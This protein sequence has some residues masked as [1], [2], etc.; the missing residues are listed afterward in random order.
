MQLEIAVDMDLSVLENLDRAFVTDAARAEESPV[1]QSVRAMGQKLI[2]VWAREA[3][4]ALRNSSGYIRD[5]DETPEWPFEDDYLHAVVTNRHKAVIYLEEGTAAF[6]MKKM[7][8][9]S[10][11]AKTSKKDGHRYLTIP[12][13]HPEARLRR[14]G[15]DPQEYQKLRGSK[16]AQGSAQGGQ[17]LYSWGERLTDVGGLGVR[18]KYFI[19]NP[20]LR[21]L[22]VSKK[23]FSYRWKTS[24]YENLY[25]F[26]DKA[27]KT[28][29]Y[30][31]FRTISEKSDPAS[32]IHPGIRAMNIAGNAVEA[33][34][35]EFEAAV[36]AAAKEM[37]ERFLAGVFAA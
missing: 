37:V 3:T 28:K 24:P 25:R 11:K 4:I 16:L 30:T 2:Q 31:T 10:A 35:P 29:G 8:Q 32:W 33:I 36:Q 6:D 26:T 23:I 20:S 21:E 7:L 27:E 18:K 22:A 15:L 12:F 9:T 17:R 5:L 34:R 19:A 14:A 13:E 1:A